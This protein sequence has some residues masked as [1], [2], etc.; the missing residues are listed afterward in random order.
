MAISGNPQKPESSSDSDHAMPLVPESDWHGLDRSDWK[1]SVD[2]SPWEIIGGS[3]ESFLSMEA[4]DG[5]WY[6]QLQP[7][8]DDSDKRLCGPLRIQRASDGAAERF[9]DFLI[10]ADLYR[11]DGDAS[12][13][14][15]PI[16]QYQLYID[17]NW[18]P[19]LPWAGYFGHLK[20]KENN[21]VSYDSGK[22]SFDADHHS[23]DRNWFPDVSAPQQSHFDISCSQQLVRHDNL[24]QDTLRLTG[25]ASIG[26]NHYRLIATK[27]SPFCRGC[28]VEVDEMQDRRWIPDAY[29]HGGAKESFTGVFRKTG[30]DIYLSPGNMD[31]PEAVELSRAQLNELLEKKK[32]LGFECD[33][34]SWRLWM[35]VAS[36]LDE[37]PAVTN[38]PW[39]GV[40]FDSMPSD[41][42]WREGVAVFSDPPVLLD[43][44]P[45][46]V[47]DGLKGKRL[48]DLDVA[49]LRT[50]LHEAGHAFGLIHPV[51]DHRLGK[52]EGRTIMNGTGDVKSKA[53]KKMPFPRNIEFA[54]DP[55][56]ALLLIHSPDP[57][58]A[59]GWS[60]GFYSD[61]TWPEF[62]V[63]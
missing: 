44:E 36:R 40:M 5:G 9:G 15:E 42:F 26:A 32:R 55:Q 56:N 38:E 33:E 17:P 48:G 58:V 62:I 35:L 31:I 46:P 49:F 4:L 2:A 14:P 6:L 7:E 39:F 28:R 18:Y 16:T 54:F 10:S 8:D 12:G 50:A 53:T 59:P 37:I 1:D 21:S 43:T 63:R 24:P 22:L 30:F 3:P 60:R 25:E 20:C 61:A 45:K 34:R 19:Q 41:D 23:W 51:D 57:K 52:I 27:T 47:V 29:R 13:F 11:Y